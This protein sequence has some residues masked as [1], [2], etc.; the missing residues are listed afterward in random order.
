MSKENLLSIIKSYFHHFAAFYMQMFYLNGKMADA[1]QVDSRNLEVI[2]KCGSLLT[3]SSSI[4]NCESGLRAPAFLHP[5][6]T[7]TSQQAFSAGL[8]CSMASMVM[9]VDQH[10]IVKIQ[11]ML[12]LVEI[13]IMLTSTAAD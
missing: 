10:N 9:L 11:Q 12:V 1:Q 8:S 5:L 6:K 3:L 2:S 7:S 13:S 4:Q